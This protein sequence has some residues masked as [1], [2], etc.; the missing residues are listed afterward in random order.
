MLLM[1]GLINIV[2]NTLAIGAI[3]YLFLAYYWSF[4]LCLHDI[5]QAEIFNHGIFYF[6]LTLGA[7]LIT[8]ISSPITYTIY[9]FSTMVTIQCPAVETVEE[10]NMDIND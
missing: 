6:V 2:L 7:V 3:G 1:Q 5:A 4:K 9:L 8:M 10:D